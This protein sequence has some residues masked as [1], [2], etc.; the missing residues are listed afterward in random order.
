MA[1][2]AV[3]MGAWE[4][5]AK[6]IVWSWYSGMEGGNALAEVLLGKVNPSGKLP[7]SIPFKMEDCGAN[8]LGEYPGRKLTKEEAQ[9]MDAHSTV[10]Y[11]DSIFVGYRYYDTYHVPVQY[12]FGHGL[13]YTDFSYQDLIVE[14]NQ[15][16]PESLDAEMA[17]VKIRIENVGG[18][19]GKEVVQVYVGKEESSQKRGAK[20]LRG[21]QKVALKP[22]ESKQAQI[23]LDKRAF[24]YYD[25][26][27]AEFVIEPGKYMIYVG[28]SLADIRLM[29]SVIIDE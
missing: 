10:A 5:K 6:A 25:E 20:E 21:F 23:I 8:V 14:L 17:V 29:G 2:S 15:T 3:S 18:M 11:K 19:A 13:S 4:P 16:V 7:V 1:G 9:R 12:C 24:T 27:R 28:S 26:A 22:G